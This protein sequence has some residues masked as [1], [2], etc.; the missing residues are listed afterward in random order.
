MERQG[1]DNIYNNYSIF[2]AN[3]TDGS[4]KFKKFFR[5]SSPIQIQSYGNNNFFV[6]I[7]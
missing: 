4:N 2:S 5:M 3:L 7:K 6:K 1:E